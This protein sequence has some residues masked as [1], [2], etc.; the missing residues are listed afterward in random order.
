MRVMRCWREC[1]SLLNL[2][3]RVI[4]YVLVC[5]VGWVVRDFYDVI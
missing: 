4:G 2:G 1:G 5:F 3:L